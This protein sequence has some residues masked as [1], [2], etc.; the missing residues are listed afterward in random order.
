M[1]KQLYFGGDILT[2]EKPL[3]AEAVLVENGRILE[4]GSIE[5][6]LMED[7]EN[8]DL[9]DLQ[10]KTMMPAFIDAHSHITAF[11]KTLNLVNLESAKNFTD[12]VDKLREFQKK[13]P[14][15]PGQWLTGFG[16]DHN[17]LEEKMHPSKNLL[18]R[19]FP[20]TPVI[21]AHASGHMGVINTAALNACHI[22][23]DTPDPEGGRIGR[24]EN[25][26]EPSGYL[27][28]KAFTEISSKTGALSLE[29]SCQ[30]MEEA[31]NIYLQYG[32]TT[33]QDGITKDTE[34]ALLKKM[35]EEGRLKIDIVSYPDLKEYQE[36]ALQNQPYIKS[37]RNH[38]K[39]GGY[40]IFLDGSPQGKTAWLSSPYQNSGGDCGYPIYTDQQVE[41]LMQTSLQQ[42]MQLLV[43]CNGDAAADQMIR[44]YRKA[45]EK[46]KTPGT[47]PVMI[48]AQT[49]RYDQ[50]DEMRELDMIASFFIAH[51]YYWGD[52]HQQNLGNDRAERISPAHTALEKGVLFTFH[53]D[54]PVLPPNMLE[55][56]WCAV[57][58]LTR[59]GTLLG[60]QER[61]TVLDALQ[62]VTI[63]AARQYREERKKGSIAPGKAADFVIM[64]QNPLKIS[65]DRIR[66]IQ[67]V[68]TI[69]DGKILYPS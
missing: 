10:G 20:D 29:Q 52:I 34:W 54:T 14:L 30:L 47:R 5:K 2:M 37:Y 41:E 68:Q 31:Q 40:K 1:S 6:L 66:E 45:L 38:L 21:I 22:T 16:Y 42:H 53:Q 44:C 64:D 49:V 57:Q 55:T 59:S 4:A 11:A 50:L 58:R 63:N 3:Y 36:I 32:I 28:E 48:H 62:A 27:E 17:F 19:M 18:D 35:A 7:P 13:H 39:I 8:I 67:I 23:A 25:S 24:M 15:N 56:V 12:L 51:T 33:A 26:M 46:V 60:A 9:V 65:P 43:H 61:I 69:K